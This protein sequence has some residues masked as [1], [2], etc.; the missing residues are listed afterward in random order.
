M[1]QPMPPELPGDP[2]LRR[3]REYITALFAG[4]LILATLVLIF[5]AASNAGSDQ[6]FGRI[7]DLLLFINPLVG[8]AVGYYFSKA[9]TQS[10]VEGAEATARDA[11]V[12]AQALHE[13][14]QEAEAEAT[15]AAQAAVRARSALQELV[16]AT[17]EAVTDGGATSP[18]GLVL[19]DSEAAPAPAPVDLDLVLALERARRVLDH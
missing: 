19:G 16:T 17:E 9:T 13:A 12:H 8:V 6:A 18:A 1:T 3:F 2:K 5:M 15:R 14:R 11:T 7:K 10:A 4:L